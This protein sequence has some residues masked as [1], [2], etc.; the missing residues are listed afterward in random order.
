MQIG[1]L[2][3]NWNTWNA[4]RITDYKLAYEMQIGLRKR[5]LDYGNANWDTECQL[6]YN[7]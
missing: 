3:A 7:L 5:K 6:R 1:L 2:G 4:S